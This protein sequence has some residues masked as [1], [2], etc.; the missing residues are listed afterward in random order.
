M[1]YF[2]I[3][4]HACCHMSY[5]YAISIIWSSFGSCR[6]WYTK[7]GTRKAARKRWFVTNGCMQEEVTHSLKLHH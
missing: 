1:L 6:D 3:Y 7:K 5:E 2:I 4:S